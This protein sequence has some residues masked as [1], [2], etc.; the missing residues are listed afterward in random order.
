[1]VRKTTISTE[2]ARKLN[3]QM[4]GKD[5]ICDSIAGYIDNHEMRF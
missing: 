3:V 2:V 4:L 5:D 1:M